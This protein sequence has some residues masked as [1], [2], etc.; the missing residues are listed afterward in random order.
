MPTWQAFANSKVRG[1]ESLSSTQPP[2]TP[3]TRTVAAGW[4]VER[5]PPAGS[6]IDVRRQNLTSWLGA[7]STT[8]ASGP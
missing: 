3:G 7:C 2:Q 5:W 8:S 4:A 1:F 6:V